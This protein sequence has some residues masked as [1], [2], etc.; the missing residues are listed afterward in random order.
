LVIDLPNAMLLNVLGFEANIHAQYQ[1]LGPNMPWLGGWQYTSIALLV[2]LLIPISAVLFTR[3]RTLGQ[4]THWQ[5]AMLT[6]I[7]LTLTGMAI[8]C[9]IINIISPQ[10]WQAFVQNKAPLVYQGTII[11]GTSPLYPM[12]VLLALGLILALLLRFTS[13]S[14]HL[15][16][17]PYTFELALTA[18]IL[19]GWFTR[20]L[21]NTI[22]G[23]QPPIF[24][25]DGG[26][27]SAA[28]LLITSMIWLA[29]H[30]STRLLNKT[31]KAHSGKRHWLVRYGTLGLSLL[32][33]TWLVHVGIAFSD[34]PDSR[35]C[36][37]V[38]HHAAVLGWWIKL[39]AAV[40]LMGVS[41]AWYFW[42]E[43]RYLQRSID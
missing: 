1:H 11:H 8:L 9:C 4:S 29:I 22:T 32:I 40:C 7:P 30:I 3:T 21:G 38:F 2:G 26:Y 27:D 19:L 24:N 28:F 33:G 10:I 23:K 12:I 36:Q 42:L 25:R 14:C 17:S 6:S 5:N 20:L 41:V 18:L 43:S 16:Q 35:W 37:I 15:Q 31:A 34:L 13:L 39:T